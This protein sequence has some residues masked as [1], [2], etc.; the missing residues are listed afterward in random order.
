MLAMR[1]GTTSHIAGEW[2][3]GDIIQPYE[4]YIY[5]VIYFSIKPNM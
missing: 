5:I 1:Q 3:M 4:Q 2:N